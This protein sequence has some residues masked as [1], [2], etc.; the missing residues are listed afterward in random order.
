MRHAWLYCGILIALI[1]LFIISLGGGVW[2][3]EHSIGHWTGK[4]L[5]GICHQNP[6]RSFLHNGIPMAVNT[7]CFGIFAGLLA[8][9]A[10]IPVMY[11]LRSKKDWTL[12]LLLFAV[13]LQIID[14]SGNLAGLWVNTNHSRF[15]FGLLLGLSVPV[16]LSELFQPKTK[17]LLKL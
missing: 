15:I 9:W 11:R 13:M 16:F 10:A 12:W 2:G 7:R 14:Y 1:F 17:K 6:D 3:A 4:L 8:G 5:Q